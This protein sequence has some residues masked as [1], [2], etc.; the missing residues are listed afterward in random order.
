MA[1]F[2]FVSSPTTAPH[3]WPIKEPGI[4]TQDKMVILK[5][6][7]LLGQPVFQVKFLAS[8]SCL[9]KS[10]ACHAASRLNLDLVT[11]A[12][13]AAPRECSKS[14]PKEIRMDISLMGH[15]SWRYSPTHLLYLKKNKFTRGKKK[16][17][18]SFKF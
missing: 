3:L 2:Y 17:H 16:V 18:C 1:F 11:V 14:Y 13:A 7:H 8:T 4:Q 9:S 12:R 15:N 10:L 5:C 6:C